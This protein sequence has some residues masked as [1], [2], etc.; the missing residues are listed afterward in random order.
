MNSAYS[1]YAVTV[2][3]RCISNFRPASQ[4]EGKWSLESKAQ[5]STIHIFQ[6]TLACPAKALVFGLL[7]VSAQ[8]LAVS[9]S[10][11]LAPSV[12]LISKQCPR[13]SHLGFHLKETSLKMSLPP[14]IN[15]RH[16]ALGTWLS[17][18]PLITPSGHTHLL[19][20]TERRCVSLHVL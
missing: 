1:N 18:H 14:H 6:V 2:E 8:I 16:S 20:T 11:L 15:F 13:I 5:R 7:E 4:K 9:E 3:E 19:G 10:S 12:S 17:L